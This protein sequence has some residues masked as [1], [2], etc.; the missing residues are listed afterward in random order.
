MAR[1]TVAVLGLAIGLDLLVGEPRTKL[2]PVAWFGGLVDRL[3]REWSATDRGQQIAGYAI[4]VLA[5]LV[6]AGAAFG[7]VAG[8][9]ALDS[10]LG[11]MAAGLVLFFTVSL[12]SLLA[13]TQTVLAATES[14]LE[15]ARTE[16]RGLVGRDTSQLSPAALRSAAIE[17]AAEN[18]SDGFVAT[19][20]PFAV[21]APISVPLAAAVAAWVKGVNTLDSMLG[22]RDR[23][24]GTGSARLDDVVMW[25]PAR[26]TA[27]AIA[28]AAGRPGIVREARHSAREPPSPNAGWPMATLAHALEIRLAKPGVYVLNPTGAEPTVADGE[29]AVTLVALAAAVAIVGAVVLAT[30]S[31]ALLVLL[32]GATSSALDGST[33]WSSSIST[34]MEVGL[35]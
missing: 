2:H 5:P 31:D 13:L 10:R 7:L 3:D 6:P 22:Y 21:L 15:S 30:A 25:L 27:G 24:L 20:V 1:T 9:L 11:A 12:R 16:I 34:A 32:N 8:G 4:A 26:L 33:R 17:S 35:S 14:D 23:R 29:R 19:L 18:L 28:I